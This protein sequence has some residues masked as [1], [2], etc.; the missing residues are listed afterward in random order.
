MTVKWSMLIRIMFNQ[1]FN[2]RKWRNYL[3]L[4][5]VSVGLNISYHTGCLPTKHTIADHSISQ[6]Q[7]ATY[8]GRSAATFNNKQKASARLCH[9]FKSKTCRIV[10]WVRWMVL[11]NITKVENLF[12]DKSFSLTKSARIFQTTILSCNSLEFWKIT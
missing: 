10:K 3:T 2:C 7:Y 5:S 9:C 4:V 8:P 1:W 11:W 12:W 6:M